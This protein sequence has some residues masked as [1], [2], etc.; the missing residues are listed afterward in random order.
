MLVLQLILAV[1][2]EMTDGYIEEDP[3]HDLHTR[4]I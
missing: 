4:Q 2:Y 1:L 3:L